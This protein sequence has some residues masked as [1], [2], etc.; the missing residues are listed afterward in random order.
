[1]ALRSRPAAVVALGAVLVAGTAAIAPPSTG[2]TASFTRTYASLAPGTIG[3]YYTDRYGVAH[4]GYSSPAVGDVT[5]DG[6]LDLVAGQANGYVY[7]YRATDGAFET[8][9]QVDPTPGTVIS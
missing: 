4:N 8:R 3:A 1:M 2:A 5:G 6:V 9:I 7:V